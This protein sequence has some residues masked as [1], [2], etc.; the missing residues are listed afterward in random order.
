VIMSTKIIVCV[1]SQGAIGS[2]FE[3]GK[4]GP[5]RK[6]PATEAG[7]QEFGSLLHAHPATPVYLMADSVE[8]DYHV[9]VLPHVSGSARH[10]LLQ[11]KLKQLY[12]N[13]PYYTAWVQGRDSGKRRDDRYLFAALTNGDMLRPWLDVLHLHQA[14]LAGMFLLP[15][16]SQELLALLKLSQ[17]DILLVSRHHDG[18]RQSFFQGGQLKASR[19]AV[20]GT[21]NVAAASLMAEIGK[22]RLYLNSLR[23]AARE[24]RL[25]VLLL[26]SDD[27]ME[28]LQQRLQADPS[29]ACQRLTRQELNVRLKSMPPGNCPYTT[30]MTVLGL[31]HPAC[32][33]AP[34][35]A[36]RSHWLHRQRRVLY[37]ASAVAAAVS[38]IWA[39]ANLFQQYQFDGETRRLAGQTQDQLARYVEVTKTFPQ[40]PASADSLE[41]AVQLADHLKQDSRTPERMMQVVSR[42]LETSTEI[43]LMRLSWK[44]GVP[45]ESP[46]KAQPV[47]PP[48]VGGRWQEWGMVEAEVRPFHGDY[49]AAMAGINRFADKL[50]HDPDIASTSVIQ[51]P[52]NVHSASA[53]S[54][55]TL[56]TA[57]TDS[58]RA[59]FKLKLVLKARP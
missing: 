2:L 33:L 40:S 26:D 21:E 20:V 46:D 45:G 55:N 53:L 39:G 6:F 43:A 8:E 24:S 58:V 19:L 18:L 14:P 37:G 7:Q 29:F 54:G 5:C 4:L 36:T 38:L 16:V 48:A 22:T 3:H 42:A 57:S 59:E 28:E 1:T 25:A 47:A 49:R 32:N 9:E 27:S 41:K 12:R 13:T 52:L 34:A 11:R 51:M 56:D 10:E 30:H 23:L 35:S 44:Y 17:P 15:M 50:K 31:R